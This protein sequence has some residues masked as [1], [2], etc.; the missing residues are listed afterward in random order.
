MTMNVSFK[1]KTFEGNAWVALEDITGS[2]KPRSAKQ[3][4]VLA[5]SQSNEKTTL[6]LDYRATGL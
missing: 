1:T 4:A 5:R 6:T 2:P 3:G